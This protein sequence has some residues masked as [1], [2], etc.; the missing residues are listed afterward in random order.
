MMTAKD[1]LQDE[2]RRND[3][4]V[5]ALMTEIKETIDLVRSELRAHIEE[6]TDIFQKAFPNGDPVGHR[7]AHEAEIDRIR[8]RTAFWHELRNHLA[9]WGL[10]GLA[11]WLVFLVWQ[12]VL[13]G[14]AP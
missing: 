7:H 12:G 13:K 3:T 10:I 2:R 6:E 8:E 4:L 14:P 11:S 1:D 5:L 9:K